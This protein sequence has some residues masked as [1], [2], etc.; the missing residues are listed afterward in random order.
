MV[1][2]QQCA[3]TLE[4]N[5]KNKVFNRSFSALAARDFLAGATFN[6]LYSHLR[7]FTASYVLSAGFWGICTDRKQSSASVVES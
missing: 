2:D 1:F 6:G 5:Q 7:L 3:K 4:G